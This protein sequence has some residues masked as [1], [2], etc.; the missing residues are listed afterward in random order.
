ME[1]K[2]VELIKVFSVGLSFNF[3][4]VAPY[5]NCCD[6]F[7]FDT[8]GKERGGNGIRFDWTLLNGYQLDKPYFLSGGIGGEDIEL[9]DEFLKTKEALNCYAID[10][11]SRFESN[12]VLKDVDRLKDFINRLT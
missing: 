12:G 4:I 11:N 1:L 10:V 2:N 3:A 5:E 8:K 9:I 6:Y 7:L